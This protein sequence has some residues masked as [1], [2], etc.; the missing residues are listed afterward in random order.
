MGLRDIERFHRVAE[1]LSEQE[2]LASQAR[3]DMEK[4]GAQRLEEGALMP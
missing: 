4:Y 3:I 2:T 1:A